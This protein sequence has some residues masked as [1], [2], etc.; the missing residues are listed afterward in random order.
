MSARKNN[1]KSG[2]ATASKSGSAKARKTPKTA[3]VKKPRTKIVPKNE[4]QEERK[5]QHVSV[6]PAKPYGVRPSSKLA[7]VIAML[8]QRGGTTV[9]ALSEAT[10]WQP[11]SVR[12]AL[13]G[14]LKKKLGLAVVSEKSGEVRTYRIGD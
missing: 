6:G 11:H 4:R 12:G 8:Q 5:R 14:A 9:A 1:R 2:A 10:G 13:A 7:T 3:T